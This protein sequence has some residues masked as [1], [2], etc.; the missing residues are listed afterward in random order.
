M[1]LQTSEAYFE[2][3]N[4]SY[5]CREMTF[6]TALQWIKQNK[7]SGECVADM[8]QHWINYMLAKVSLDTAE[9][10]HSWIVWKR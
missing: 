7:Y 8:F 5:E 10:C 2:N 9:A 4:T 6:S 3:L 1:T